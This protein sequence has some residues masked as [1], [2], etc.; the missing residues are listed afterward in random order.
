MGNNA[1]SKGPIQRDVRPFLPTAWDELMS[2]ERWATSRN[3]HFIRDKAT[4]VEW[5]GPKRRQDV[6]DAVD[7][8]KD[9]FAFPLCVNDFLAGFALVQQA[10]VLRKFEYVL[11][12]K[13]SLDWAAV[14]QK[15]MVVPDVVLVEN[16]ETLIAD[17][18]HGMKQL[19]A[20]EYE[21][22][23]AADQMLLDDDE[24]LETGFPMAFTMEFLLWKSVTGN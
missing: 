9:F 16:L 18:L 11:N 12:S 10:P 24:V 21:I 13:P 19:A 14:I 7:R 2:L 5:F 3:L 6:V 1:C 15:L 8:R 23:V 17:Q 22:G 4:L 20:I